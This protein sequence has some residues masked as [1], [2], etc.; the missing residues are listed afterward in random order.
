MAYYG[1][2][3]DNKGAGGVRAWRD[4]AEIANAALA[5]RIGKKTF[6]TPGAAARP[7]WALEIGKGK[8]PG[9]D[10]DTGAVGMRMLG[11]CVVRTAPQAAIDLAKSIAGSAAEGS[12]ISQLSLVRIWRH[13][14][15]PI[16]ARTC[17][18]S[19]AICSALLVA[20]PLYHLLG[21]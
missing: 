20:E 19:A 13:A 17:G 14:F 1:G 2:C 21:N 9:R 3:N 18:S 6:E 11:D 7:G 12:A 5:K 15:R 8:V 10:Y 4:R 16:S